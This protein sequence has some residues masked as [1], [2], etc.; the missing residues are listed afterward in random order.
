MRVFKFGG[1]SVKDAES[2]INL[3]DILK[4]F[5]NEKIVV[6]ISAMGKMTN[7]FEKLTDVFFNKQDT[8]ESLNFIKNY[9]AEIAKK[10]FPDKKHPVYIE[11]SDIF[12]SLEKHL[13]KE[14][15]AD[16]DFEYD[17]IVSNGEIIST[18]IVSAYLND[19]GIN[20]HWLNA[21]E[22][23]KTDNNYRDAKVN[24]QLTQEQTKKIVLPLFSN[25]NSIVLTQGFIGCATDGSSV[26]LGREGSDYS[27][28]IIAYSLDASET[29]IW[30]DVSGV[31]NA[32]PKWFD[33]TIKLE[34][35]SYHD[36]I[37]LAYYGATVIHPKTI[38][39]LQNKQIPLFV[40]S[41]IKPDEP[42]TLIKDDITALKV[43]SFIFKINQVLITISPKD[44]SFIVEEN[45]RDIFHVFSEMKTKINVM[46]NSALR[47]SVCVDY[48][49]RRMP[50]LISKLKEKFKVLYNSG[51]ELITIRHYDQQ[52]IDRVCVEKEVLLEQKS[53]TTVQ[54]VV[55]PL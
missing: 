9:H 32:D 42:G 43:P 48:D 15:S 39:P 35:I 54:L 22:I 17:Q 1:A 29:V 20:C 16:Y 37:E 47:F 7:A 19:A 11:L 27:A 38:K 33:E 2:V 34:Q 10:L 26:T 3:A 21:K 8:T 13:K 25:K 12:G 45:L 18:K 31:L 55:K 4:I 24:W 44:F 51:L 52:T 46:Q 41:F 36:A 23:I 28:A 40:R 14:P 6:I 30:K 50:P 53:R 49:K 5:D